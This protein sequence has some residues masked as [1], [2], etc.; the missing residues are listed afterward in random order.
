MCS[1]LVRL[2][3]A[4]GRREGFSRCRSPERRGKCD[5]GYVS[6]ARPAV[7]RPTKYMSQKSGP[8][9]KD[10]DPLPAKTLDP[11][12]IDICRI[13]R[14]FLPGVNRRGSACGRV[15]SPALPRMRW[16]A[17]AVGIR[18][19]VPALSRAPCDGIESP[20]TFNM[21]LTFRVTGQELVA[22][23]IWSWPGSKACHRAI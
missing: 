13:R 22:T 21:L 11:T 8:R 7:Q 19:M 1:P 6:K 3:S 4:G 14:N 23:L 5:E 17:R 15:P 12:Q 18:P 10:R 20:I 9:F 2:N 16:M